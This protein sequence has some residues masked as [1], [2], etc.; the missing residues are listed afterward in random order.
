MSNDA[1]HINICNLM[2]ITYIVYCSGHFSKKAAKIFLRCTAVIPF[3]TAL[4]TTENNKT[5]IAHR[6]IVKDLLVALCSDYNTYP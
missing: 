1:T 6:S 4:G 3:V 5:N 2:G